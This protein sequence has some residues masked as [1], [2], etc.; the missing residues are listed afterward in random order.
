MAAI[1]YK[2][3]DYLA[4]CLFVG[5][6][7]F[8]YF[9][10]G[11]LRSALYVQASKTKVDYKVFLMLGKFT[12]RMLFLNQLFDYFWSFVSLQVLKLSN[13]PLNAHTYYKII[14]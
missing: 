11:P 2:M 12:I 5:S 7:E 8:T 9:S 14:Q 6:Q 10:V 4:N 1:L 13:E 3:F